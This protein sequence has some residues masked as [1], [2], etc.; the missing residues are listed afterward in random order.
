MKQRAVT[1]ILR[2]PPPTI[3]SQEA[4]GNQ[5]PP[6]G[7][8]QPKRRYRQPVYGRPILP[9]FTEEEVTVAPTTTPPATGGTGVLP[10]HASACD[11]DYAGWDAP[12]LHFMWVKYMAITRSAE[13]RIKAG[14]ARAFREVAPLVV[15]RVEKA[16]Q[17][18]FVTKDGIEAGVDLF[19]VRTLRGLLKR[20]TEQEIADI[21][22]EVME[23]ALSQI[24]K[25]PD[26]IQSDFDVLL[27]AALDESLSK[28]TSAA[29]TVK[30]QVTALVQQLHNHPAH[31]ITAAIQK[32][33][34]FYSTAGASR[35]ARTSAA[36]VRT[37]GQR[38]AWS[39]FPDI[40]PTWLDE[41]RRG[42]SHRHAHMR[43]QRPDEEGMFSNSKTGARGRG[44]GQLNR[45]GDA[46]NCMCV[47]RPRRITD[48]QS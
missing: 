20:Y 47:L 10:L 2:R 42:S 9:P 6:K 4:G 28:I 21:F 40:I 27:S 30:K 31:E 23:A 43:G 14:V 17:Q 5:R 37:E 46:I 13:E 45:A 41:Q 8:K 36:V 7:R 26:A 22:G 34:D 16:L 15:G 48:P 11:A 24:G 29:G 32:A 3:E 44:P 18:G 33:F 19:D 1:L 25:N 12:S 38:G 39:P 35:I